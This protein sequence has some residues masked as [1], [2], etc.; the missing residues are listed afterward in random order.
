MPK[1]N[2]LILD[3]I[4]NALKSKKDAG[5]NP[6]PYVIKNWDELLEDY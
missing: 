3:R 5:R 4:A 2:E 6:T 1:A